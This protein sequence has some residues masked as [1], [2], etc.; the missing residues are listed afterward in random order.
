MSYTHNCGQRKNLLPL[1]LL[2]IQCLMRW[3]RTGM[4]SAAMDRIQVALSHSLLRRSFSLSNVPCCPQIPYNSKGYQRSNNRIRRTHCKGA[5]K[6]PK[7]IA[8]GLEEG[9]GVKRVGILLGTI[10]GYRAGKRREQLSQ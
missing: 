8:H 2:L 10:D 9:C 3:H 7:E 4:G 5:G 6:D 1:L